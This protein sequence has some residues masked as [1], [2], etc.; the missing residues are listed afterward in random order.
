LP[1]DR[2][3][4]LREFYST[5][6]DP[7]LFDNPTTPQALALD[8]ISNHDTMMVC[9]NDPKICHPIQRYVMAVMYF[10]LNGY[11]WTKCTA[12]RDFNCQDEIDNKNHG[13]DIVPSPHYPNESRI[14]CYDALA[15]LS[16]SHECMWG[17][18]AC[19]GDAHGP[20]EPDLSYCVDQIELENNSLKGLIPHEIS[21]L[22]HMRFFAL[23]QGNITGTLPSALGSLKK[24]EILDVDYNK[25][26]GSIPDEIY[27]LEH[28][29]EIDLNN[30]LLTGT[31]SSHVGK[32][33]K[34]EILQ[35]DNNL[36]SG[37]IPSEIRKLE[38]L[39]EYQFCLL[40]P[41]SL[42]RSCS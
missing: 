39:G 12:P 13:C 9:P 16:P 1:C 14:G 17:G 8:W 29:R 26:T 19:L 20:D 11:Q 38:N 40:V 21:N 23:E 37:N 30:N 28:L 10:S 3:K 34:L 41:F 4:A 31:L 15:W 42:A 7:E 32:L 22:E 25:L 18:V 5:I 33:Q 24:L 6:S 36:L 27:T 35:V 2:R